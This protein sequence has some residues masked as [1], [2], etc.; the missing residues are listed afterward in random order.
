MNK[1]K[2]IKIGIPVAAGCI[3]LALGIG[4]AVKNSGKAVKVAPVSSVNSGGWYDDSGIASYG[5]V[6]TNQKQDI[7]VDDTMP[8]TQV[9]V[10]AGDTVKVGDR[11]VAYDTTLSSLELEMKEM[12]IQGIDLNI[13]NLQKEIT[14]LKGTKTAK[15][16]TGA[17]VVQ[18]SADGEQQPTVQKMSAVKTTVLNTSKEDEN[19]KPDGD[20]SKD[21][22]TKDDNTKDDVPSS[23]IERP[24]PE[25]L[26]GKEVYSEITLDSVPYNKEDADGTMEKP[27]RYL[28]APGA[29]VNAP[30][31]LKVLK[32][33]QVCAFDVVDNAEA[34][35]KF[36]SCWI[37]DG[38]TGQVVIPDPQPTPD[39][40][41]TP[42]PEPTP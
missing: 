11:L 36:V 6:T 16:D 20:T 27:Y 22:T 3:V 23:A 33:G 15:A 41:P 10:K 29:A 42:N 28:C 9:Y 34:P 25:A 24:F 40:E 32:E 5:T 2:I 13:Q 39:P 17:S 35:T 30:F 19:K 14:Q 31:M 26:K 7:Y 1:K 37:L 8:I 12:Q 4:F 18:T 38:K 21:D